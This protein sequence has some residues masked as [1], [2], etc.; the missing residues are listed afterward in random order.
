M[1]DAQ[2][3]QPAWRPFLVPAV[4]AGM[5]GVLVATWLA[6]H[7]GIPT[8][9]LIL[10]A[11]LLA[12]LGT[13]LSARA[14]WAG[15]ALAGGFLVLLYLIA[16]ERTIGP[17]MLT[18]PAFLAGAV[19]RRHRDVTEQLA[20]R[21]RELEEERELFTTL[22]VQHERARIAAELHDVLGHAIS[23]MVVQAAAGQRL[24]TTDPDG[25]RAS[26][27]AI[28]HAAE[29]GQ[30]DLQRL[31][32]LLDGHDTRPPDL[33][34]IDELLGTAAAA[35]LRVSCRIEGERSTIPPPAAHLAL[36]TVQEGLTN[37]L[38]HA[39]GSTVQVLV[40][41]TDGRL[42][43]RVENDAPPCR[44]RPVLTGTGRGLVGLR[45]RAQDLG[46]LLTAGPTPTGGWAVEALLG[47]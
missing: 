26:L 23:V 39:P 8:V 9:L 38:R 30:Q 3:T 27:L 42:T 40:S 11:A 20:A 47:D 10:S 41:T 44:T 46:G 18:V 45:E 22:S 31:V 28:A 29:Q 1:V 6:G 35:G 33:A 5:A 21:G 24:A 34:L 43:V 4:V 36:R 19:L 17:L 16:G 14:A 15:A 2:S 32:D 37:A 12:V 7:G 13:T 25:A